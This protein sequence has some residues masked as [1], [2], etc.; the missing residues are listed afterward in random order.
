MLLECNNLP[1]TL[2]TE[3]LFIYT[4]GV[5]PVVTRNPGR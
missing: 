4:S 2:F 1:A 3:I 5:Q